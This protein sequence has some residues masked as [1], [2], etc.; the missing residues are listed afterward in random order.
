MVLN[1]MMPSV[2]SYDSNVP[3]EV[4][5]GAMKPGCRAATPA[6]T[7]SQTGRAAEM[8]LRSSARVR[9]TRSYFVCRT[10]LARSA[11]AWSN[12]P[13]RTRVRILVDTA[14]Y[15]STAW[16][17]AMTEPEASSNSASSF[18]VSVAMPGMPKSF[19]GSMVDRAAA[20]LR[21]RAS[22]SACRLN[23][24]KRSQARRSNVAA[25][26]IEF[27][28]D[29]LGSQGV[30]VCLVG[31]AGGSEL[32]LPDKLFGLCLACVEGGVCGGVEL[33]VRVGAELARLVASPGR[34]ELCLDLVVSLGDLGELGGIVALELAGLVEA[35]LGDAFGA[36]GLAALAAL[37][38]SG[39]AVVP[40]AR[41]DKRGDDNQDDDP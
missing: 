10:S 8:I 41:P 34:S 3:I 21:L 1:S 38:G 13:L 24:A 39:G 12:W 30:G 36:N 2:A 22:T 28:D 37:P 40:A 29:G 20:S 35:G 33:A 32:V 7:A 6:M 9:R 5:T 11:S 19:A 15:A 27:L 17:S 4:S 31:V 14:W 16:R 23:S 25:G 18:F 26:G